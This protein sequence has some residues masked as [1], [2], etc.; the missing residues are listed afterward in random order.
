MSKW[1]DPRTVICLR[2]GRGADERDWR[3]L[4]HPAAVRSLLT[5]SAVFS[6]RLTPRARRAAAGWESNVDMTTS[7]EIL[8]AI[9]SQGLDDDT[10]PGVIRFTLGQGGLAHEVVLAVPGDVLAW[11]IHN[12]GVSAEPACGE[13]RGVRSKAA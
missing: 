10:E 12:Y 13:E 4:A 5:A 2:A 1:H 6:E 9:E 11:L 3:I 8:W 7:D